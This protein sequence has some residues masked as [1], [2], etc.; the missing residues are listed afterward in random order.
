MT[1]EFTSEEG[2]TAFRN[3]MNSLGPGIGDG[4]TPNGVLRVSLVE[5]LG[6]RRI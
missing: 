3:H 5:G 6:E 2:A 4:L 1:G